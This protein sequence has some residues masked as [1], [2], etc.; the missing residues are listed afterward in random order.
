[1]LKNN[2]IRKNLFFKLAVVFL[3]GVFISG[4][5]PEPKVFAQNQSRVQE[6]QDQIRD[7]ELAISELEKQIA[8]TELKIKASRSAQNTLQ[9]AIAILNA[10]QQKFLK[11]ISLTEG[12]I[13][14]KELEIES[15]SYEIGDKDESIYKSNTGL[16][17]IIREVDR[18]KS[19]SMVVAILSQ[20]N[21]SEFWMVIEE[22]QALNNALL[23]HLKKLKETKI[24]L[25]SDI[26]EAESAKN[27]LR[28]LQNELV[29]R[30]RIVDANKNEQ[31]QLLRSTKN[32]ESTYQRMLRDQ[33]AKRKAFEQELFDFESALRFEIDR[34]L[35]PDP[36]PGVLSWPLERVRIT[37]YFGDTPFSR[38]NPGVYSGRGHN[39]ID[40]GA[41]VGTPILAPASGRIIGFGDTDQVCPNASYGKWIL[42][43]H[44]NGLSTLYAHLSV[45][46]VTVGQN[47]RLGERIGYTGNTG[48]STGP[49]LH[50]TVYAT[51]GVKIMDRPSK[52][53]GGIYTMPIADLRAYLNPLLYLPEL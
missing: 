21:I 15:L 12:K 33:E 17:Q 37:Q 39:G 18:V 36:R 10:E 16:A 25:E 6:L 1:M 22:N 35:L 26:V 24:S 30:K 50:F 13:K 32:E 44:Y 51:Q 52:A 9:G 2:K 11:E 23:Q 46:D 41:P 3:I 28:V 45:I 29:A 5:F 20:K 38:Q 43:E 53:C 48:Y 47:I 40:L 49:H 8:E 42:M 27:E 31:D 34:S 14:N 4:I 19:Q 7:R